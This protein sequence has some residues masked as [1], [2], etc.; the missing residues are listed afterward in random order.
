[1]PRF[2]VG[3]LNVGGADLLLVPFTTEFLKLQPSEQGSVHRQ[4]TNLCKMA[5][6]AGNVIPVWQTASGSMAFLAEERFHPVLREKLSLAFLQQCL[7]R[8]VMTPE[9]GP[10]VQRVLAE[11]SMEPTVATVPARGDAELGGPVPPSPAPSGPPAA[12]AVSSSFPQPTY[13][14]NNLFPRW[15]RGFPTRVV[16]M[17]FT[18]VVDSTKLK[19]QM[20][21]RRGTEVIRKHHDLIRRLLAQVPGGHFISTSGD[22]FFC[23]FVTPSEAVKFA[24]RMQNTIRGHIFEDGIRMADRVGI[25]LGEV[26]VEERGAGAEKPLDLHGIQVDTTARIMSLASA[27]QIL[28]SRTTAENARQVMRGMQ[29]EGLANIQ[30]VTH[31][32]YDMKGVE[33]PIEI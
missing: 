24:L 4:I 18:D 16:T 23:I 5:R 12:P 2:R 14:P 11:V 7:N 1:M 33:D 29:I 30:W 25:H 15:D 20:G 3:H 22:S 17:L 21:D 27:D 8:E 19:Q 32:H 6:L 10:L 28:M 13:A 9:L 31:G 26:F